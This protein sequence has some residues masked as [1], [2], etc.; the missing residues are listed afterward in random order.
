MIDPTSSYTLGSSLRT[1]TAAETLA[2]AGP[3]AARLGITRVTDITRLDRVGIPVAAS[4][5]P[6]AHP[7]SLCV[8]AGKGLTAEDA[9]V[10]AAMEAIEF[11]LA[12]PGR[13]RVEVMTTKP[14]RIADG[15]S[16]T[17]LDLCPRFGVRIDLDAEMVCAAAE[18]L[19]SGETWLLPADLIFHPGPTANGNT[20]YYQASTNGLASGNTVLEATVH[21]LAEVIE[22]DIQSFQHFLNT[23]VLVQSQSLPDF[24]KPWLK[25]IA[26]VGLDL[27]VRYVENEFGLPF[28]SSTV[29]DAQAGTPLYVNGGFGVHTH[30]SISL[31]RAITEAIQSRLSFIHGGRDSMT[32]DYRAYRGW[33]AQR[34]ADRVSELTAIVANPIGAVNFDDIPDHAAMTPDVESAYVF[35]SEAL[36]RC[37]MTR[38]CRTAFTTPEDVLQVVR[39]VV[40]GL[41]MWDDRSRRVGPRLRDY[42]EKL[43]SDS[44]RGSDSLRAA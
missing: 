40:P 24:L 31:V 21:G 1:R 38:I 42:V 37:G 19:N 16:Q 15:L 11:A 18:E 27:Y 36:G 13:S 12:E 29:V 10:G 30:R 26:D 23:S 39:I 34:L 3:I 14:I 22:R 25:A 43:Q 41:E 44:L 4:I 7:L 32:H 20:A 5:R 2:I 9:L 35:L 17:L 6:D 33:S 8:C 28:F